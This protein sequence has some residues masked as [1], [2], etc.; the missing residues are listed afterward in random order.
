MADFSV[1]RRKNPPDQVIIHDTA[2]QGTR[3]GVI[4]TLRGKGAGTHYIIDWAGRT[5][6]HADPLTEVTFHAGSFNERSVGFDN[7]NPVTPR[8][9]GR[10]M[11]LGP[12]TMPA[13]HLAGKEFV[14]PPIDA[15]EAAYVLISTLVSDP[16]LNIPNQI[17]GLDSQ[18]KLGVLTLAPVLYTLPGIFAHGQISG[19]RADGLFQLIYYAL[20]RSGN[21]GE[22]DAYRTAQEIDYGRGGYVLLPPSARAK[23][24]PLARARLQL[25]Q[26]TAR[27]DFQ[28]AADKQAATDADVAAAQYA[29]TAAAS[30][31]F[32]V[33]RTQNSGLLYDFE[34]GKWSDEA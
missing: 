17:P 14:I 32:I 13:K 19:N 12:E 9:R 8:S 25:M 6:K 28:G 1:R 34:T 22:Q 15:C 26:Y 20:R 27:K 16:A 7:I 21:F 5:T 29:K 10:I 3:G 2:G 33:E 18:G 4:K 11:D 30:G 31:K 24:V 23:D